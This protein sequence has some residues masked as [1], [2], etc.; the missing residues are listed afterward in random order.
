MRING[1]SG[2][3]LPVLPVRPT[4]TGRPIANAGILKAEG[5]TVASVSY[6]EEG[7]GFAKRE[8]Q[9]DELTRSVAWLQ[10]YLQAAQQSGSGANGPNPARRP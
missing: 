5:R 1:A 2:V 9:R 6:P 7:H 4:P 10:R 3:F 8:H